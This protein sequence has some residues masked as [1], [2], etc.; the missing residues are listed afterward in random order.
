MTGM[1]LSYEQT[2][3]WDECVQILERFPTLPFDSRVQAV[4]RLVRNPSP[5]IREQALRIGAAILP[6]SRLTAYLRD[7]ADAVLRNAGC[8]IFRLR[9]GRSLPVVVELLQDPDTDVVVQA[10][11]ILDR[12]RDP[13]ALEPLHAILGHADPNVQQE[14]IL[15]IGRLGD[16][17]SIPYLVPFLDSD[18][19]VQMAAVQALGDLRTP[20]AIPYLAERLS[21]PLAG[22]LAAEA[23]ARIG[24]EAAFHALASYWP[25]A[26]EE[27]GMEIEEEALLGL[28]AH[29]LE[30]LPGI[31]RPLPAGFRETLLPR[32]QGG[33]AELRRAAARCLLVLGPSE[34]DAAALDVLI[35]SAPTSGGLPPALLQRGDLI[36]RLLRLSDVPRSWGFLLACRFPDQVPAEEFLAALDWASEDPDLLPPLARALE[37]VSFPGLDEALLGLYLWLPI[38]HRELL[39]PALEAHGTEL[40]A[41]LAGRSEVDDL[42]RL[43]LSAWLGQ[44]TGEVVAAVLALPAP[45]RQLVASRLMRLEAVIRQLPWEAWLEEAP[46]LFGA[47]AA[48]AA[49]RYDLRALLPALRARAATAPGAAL[50]RAL[51]DLADREAVPVLLRLLASRIDLRPVVLES[52]GRIGGHEARAALREAV[53]S[54]GEGAEERI[55]YRALAACAGA[56]DDA[57]FRQATLHPDWYVRLASVDVLARFKHPENMAALVRLVAD[58]APAVAHRALALFES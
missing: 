19:W 9:G 21:D 39:E 46:E 32:L 31:P 15:A 53:L 14:A 52:L 54:G 47:L 51:G 11:L 48:E 26:G 42:D 1:Q 30:G 44:P 55:A 57:L 29:V 2:P 27:I 12:L 38:E 56:G 45:S 41:T 17:R 18:P 50:V 6:D 16:A 49:G 36:G 28:L 43:V 7:D 4:E 13:R 22:S 58:P 33:S 40:R 23:L 10:V 34:F 20:A 35:G 24:G 25:A 3:S 37:K 8:E 5:G